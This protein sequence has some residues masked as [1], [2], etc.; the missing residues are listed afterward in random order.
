MFLGVC[1]CV[2]VCVCVY[3]F[4]V[5][6]YSLPQTKL[7][8]LHPVQVVEGSWLLPK[9]EKWIQPASL[10]YRAS[11]RTVRDTQRNPVSKAK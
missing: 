3:I 11:S 9:W 1:V 8:F 7:I 2:C 6:V 10:V 5:P 4:F